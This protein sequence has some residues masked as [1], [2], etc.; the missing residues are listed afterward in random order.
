VPNRPR[1][2]AGVYDAASDW[3]PIYD[4]TA[5]HGFFV[6]MATSGNQFKNAPTVG[7]LMAALIQAVMSGHD[8]DAD[9]VRFAASYTGAGIDLGA[10]S[11]KRRLNAATSGTVF[12]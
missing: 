2:L 5:A 8:H 7:S 6:A 11:R 3:T 12:G 10:F 9:P 4:R 1:G